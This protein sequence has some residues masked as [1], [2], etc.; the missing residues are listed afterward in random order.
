MRRRLYLYFFLFLLID[1]SYSQKSPTSTS[2]LSYLLHQADSIYFSNPDSSYFISQQVLDLSKQNHDH[3]SEAKS[4][5]FIGR[6]YLL[7]SQLEDAE[8]SFNS[9]QGL[10]TDLH[11]L[12]GKAYVLKLKSI[13]LDRLGNHQES[14][15]S[16]EEAIGLYENTN[17][18]KGLITSLLNITLDYM[19]DQE[20]NKADSAVMKLENMISY[21][22]KSDY[23]YHYQNKGSLLV[24]HKKYAEALE[25][26]NKAYQVA[27]T[28]KMIDSQATILMKLGAVYTTLSR[29]SEA[30]SHLLRSKDICTKNTLDH[31]LVETYSELISLYQKMNDFKKAFECIR[32]QNDLKE[33]ILDIEKL[34]RIASLE[35]KLAISEKQ[36]ELDEE[37]INLQESKTQNQYLFFVVIFIA[38]ISGFLVF[39]FFRTRSLKNKIEEK[40][41]IIEEKQKEILDSIHYAKKIQTT[42][43]ADHDLISKHLQNYFILYKPKDIVSGDFY[44]STTQNDSFYISI[45]DSTGHGVPGAFM[46]LLNVNFLNEAVNEK[47]IDEPGKV[48]DYVRQKLI[49]N[50][51]QHD[52]KDGMDGV[53][54]RY[55][56]LDKS[57]TYSAAYNAP[58]VVSNGIIKKQLADKMPVGKGEKTDAFTTYDLN[59]QKGDVVYLFTDGYA[60]QFGGPKGKKFKQKQLE[61]LFLQ[62][63]SYSVQEQFQILNDTFLGWKGVM[64]Q[65]D[66]VLILGF[67]MS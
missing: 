39:L 64:E 5:V 67:K 37:K 22:S 48:F 61:D 26:L 58:V 53:L 41:H 54:L 13:L 46:S 52:Q 59:L 21:F 28:E 11:D 44:W 6:Y 1:V 66:D 3:A 20:L 23:Y 18:K 12:R 19:E 42:L 49:T 7:K 50:M 15:K 31:E 36:K 2:N 51:S 60:D 34:N 24:L 43:L 30:E 16:L 27:I 29:F 10:Y 17:D 35:K 32:S 56:N 63:S 33:K 4:L 14:R 8:K 38:A 62:I 45:C 9:A 65:V 25:A 57:I 47:N 55:N 40:S